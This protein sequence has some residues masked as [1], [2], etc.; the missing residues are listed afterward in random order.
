M[1]TSDLLL[2]FCGIPSIIILAAIGAFVMTYIMFSINA[3][4]NK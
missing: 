1:T 3:R 2:L 4:K